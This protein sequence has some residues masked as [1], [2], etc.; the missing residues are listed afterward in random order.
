MNRCKPIKLKQQY[1]ICSLN[2]THRF[3][4]RIEHVELVNLSKYLK[5]TARLE[6][7]GAVE[8]YKLALLKLLMVVNWIYLTSVL[9]F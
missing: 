6:L 9:S 4:S 2:G 3:N 1:T 8:I 5:I 7:H